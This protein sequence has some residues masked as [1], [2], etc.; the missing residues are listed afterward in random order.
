MKQVPTRATT[1]RQ[2]ARRR[3]WERVVVVLWDCSG[4][5][6]WRSLDRVCSEKR[7]GALCD[8]R[9][10][11]QPT[12]R[13][14]LFYIPLKAD[15]LPANFPLPVFVFLVGLGLALVVWLVGR[16]VTQPQ[17]R[18]NLRGATL[19]VAGFGGLAALVC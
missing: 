12:M 17:L 3:H 13:Q 6:K 14:V 7:R 11:C 16:R 10:G 2:N 8:L 18:E 4:W 9:K 5:M 1:C 19:W 15:W